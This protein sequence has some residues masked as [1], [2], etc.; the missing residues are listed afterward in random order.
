MESILESYNNE[1]LEALKSTNF[2]ERFFNQPLA[3]LRGGD[4]TFVHSINE[5]P[6]FSDTMQDLRWR[7]TIENKL[8][9]LTQN[10]FI[11]L[12]SITQK[13]L[14]LNKTLGLNEICQ[15]ALIEHLYHARMFKHY[16][17]E[18][19]S[20][21][22]IG[23]GSGYFSL[24]MALDGF[25]VLSTDIT[26]SFYLWQSILYHHFNI[27]NEGVINDIKPDY[28]KISH[29]PWWKFNNI[30][31]W[32]NDKI[33]TIII[34]HAITE[35]HPVSLR[36]L[37]YSAS[38]IGNPSFF[39]VGLGHQFRVSSF[40]DII[41][42][43]QEF[44]YRLMHQ[45]NDIYLLEYTSNFKKLRNTDASI[46]SSS[47]KQTTKFYFSGGNNFDNSYLGIFRYFYKKYK[48]VFYDMARF[49]YVII[50]NNTYYKRIHNLHQNPINIEN[51]IHANDI[52][53]YYDELMQVKDYMPTH[54]KQL[55]KLNPKQ[56]N[57]KVK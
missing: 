25:K 19:K 32:C 3:H 34:N 15:S 11:I 12:K 40:W 9:G 24:I 6:F 43:A 29:I 21:I 18:S 10:E 55:M 35:M 22:E 48:A 7:H 36:N 20:I 51:E 28:G 1:Q 53:K 17:S 13:V 54:Q 44:G 38:Q 50:N 8:N 52:S 37:F 33:D 39:I 16:F 49:V 47:S 57:N 31:E 45:N 2:Y 26:Q 41:G 30:Y 14:Q 56:Y 46:Q 42:I 27:L 23:P 5:L 4:P